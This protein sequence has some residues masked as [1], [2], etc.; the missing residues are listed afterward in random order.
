M[1]EK[2]KERKE[3][4]FPKLIYKR[5]KERERVNEGERERML[6]ELQRMYVSVGWL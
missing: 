5:S 6:G 1:E 2:G 4:L 3:F